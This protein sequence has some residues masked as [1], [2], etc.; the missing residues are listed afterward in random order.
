[1]VLAITSGYYETCADL[2]LV[3]E[4]R[5]KA[6]HHS[7]SAAGRGGGTSTWRLQ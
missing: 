5:D 2:S 4:E 6:L 1:M 7:P 3:K